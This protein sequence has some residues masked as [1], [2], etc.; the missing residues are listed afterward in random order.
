MP[1]AFQNELKVANALVA[2]PA[3]SA[4]KA[5]SARPAR[6]IL[7]RL[8]LALL[9]ALQLVPASYAQPPQTAVNAAS[10][11]SSSI[12]TLIN[13]AQEATH[14]IA[15]SDPRCPRNVA[16]DDNGRQQGTPRSKQ[17]FSTLPAPAAA[18]APLATLIAPAPPSSPLAAP[19]PLALVERSLSA[20]APRSTPLAHTNLDQSRRK[21]HVAADAKVAGKPVGVL[22]VAPVV[23]ADSTATTVTTKPYDVNPVKRVTSEPVSTFS[24]DVDTGAY[25]SVRGL[26]RSG[27]ALP[28]GAVRVEEMLNYF[29]YAYTR[30]EQQGSNAPFAVNTEI[31]PSPWNA[32]NQLLRIG[33]Q[34]R[35]AAKDSLPPANLVFLIDVSGSMSGERSLPM[36]QDAMLGLVQQ[37]RPQD[38]V[39]LVT[40]ASGTQVALPP[41]SGS[42]KVRL[43]EAICGLQA[44]GSTAGASGIKLAYEQ[45]KAGF[46]KDGINRILLATDGDFN[47]GVSDTDQLKTMVAAQRK[48]GISLSTLGVGYAS[49][50]DH[51]M[52]QIADAG[53]G[54]YSFMDNLQEGRKVLVNEFTSTLQTIAQDVKLQLEFNPTIVKEYRLIGYENRQLARED[55]SNDAVDA[56]DIGAGHRV[57][58]LYELT[59]V[60][61]PGLINEERYPANRPTAGTISG[62][63]SGTTAAT[64][65]THSMV[66]GELAFM[67]IRYKT[68]SDNPT[69]AKS[70]EIGQAIS[71]AAVTSIAKASPDFQFAT[72]VAA[73]AQI[74]SRSKYVGAFTL[75]DSLQLAKAS[76]GADKFGQRKEFMELVQLAQK[77]GGGEHVGQVTK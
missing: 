27:Q 4:H 6:K 43:A 56:G 55:F 58:A 5:T 24:I 3:R 64:T 52:E 76:L 11:A 14:Y 25:T 42:D 34:A 70:Q 13:T 60:G 22:I 19:A 29:D 48:N 41:T 36:V 16:L 73:A 77:A 15:S 65:P 68:P 2:P 61:K 30:P 62:T 53:D 28:A 39:S 46:V 21:E 69:T 72:A 40:Y 67:K 63:T 50:N 20:V 33:I 74:M 9:A 57:T 71:A 18:M 45:A 32:N 7:S 10:K 49:Y 59:M 66:A 1:Y 8:L 35:D 47:V 75:A 26:L 17:S 37:L 23:D 12:K 44:G 38:K 31:A 51:L 54:K